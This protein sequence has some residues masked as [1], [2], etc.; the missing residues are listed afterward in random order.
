MPD[1]R[2]LI[3]VSGAP[4]LRNVPPEFWAKLC[5]Y[6]RGQKTGTV[7]WNFNKGRLLSLGAEEHLHAPGKHEVES[8][9]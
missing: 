5:E 9:G 4:E 7:K 8:R 3:V 2:P 1:V 6:V